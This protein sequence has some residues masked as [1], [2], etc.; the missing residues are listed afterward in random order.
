MPDD[1]VIETNCVI[2]KDGATPL[3]DNDVP[4]SVL[5]LML[6]V[7]SYEE[8]TIEAAVT[9]NRNKAFLAFLNH[10]LVHDAR[11]AREALSEMLEAN[12]DY[13]AK[14]FEEQA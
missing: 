6:Q 14:F 7:K 13:L 1:S 12:K 8:L 10:P 5:G 2:G 9:G 4:A 3:Q 11:D